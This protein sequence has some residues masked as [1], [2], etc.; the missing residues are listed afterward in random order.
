MRFRFQLL[1]SCLVVLP[2]LPLSGACRVAVAQEALAVPNTAPAVIPPQLGLELQ[3]IPAASKLVPGSPAEKAGFRINDRVLLLDGK[4]VE[5]AASFVKS[6]AALPQRQVITVTVLRAGVEMPIRA[7][8]DEFAA[9]PAVVDGKPEVRGR[10]GLALADLLLVTT[11]TPGG[12]AEQAGVRRGDRIE[13]VNYHEVST[14]SEAAKY[15]TGAFYRGRAELRLRRDGAVV[16]AALE[17]GTPLPYPVTAQDDQEAAKHFKPISELYK[18]IV[19]DPVSGSDTYTGEVEFLS[20]KVLDFALDTPK[21]GQAVY[22]L[23]TPSDYVK[24]GRKTGTVYLF[25]PDKTGIS[26]FKTGDTVYLRAKLERIRLPEGTTPLELVLTGE[27]AFASPGGAFNP[28][29]PL[30]RVTGEVPKDALSIPD[31]VK[32]TQANAAATETKLKGKSMLFE[33]VPHRLVRVG[34]D[35]S[36]S[37][38]PDGTPGS[39]NRDSVSVLFKGDAGGALKGFKKGERVRFQGRLVK[40]AVIVEEVDDFLNGGKKTERTLT[41]TFEADNIVMDQIPL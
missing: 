41:V 6:V 5:N 16:N 30:L 13:W 14:R 4:K 32:Q 24:A 29:R 27:E 40:A 39:K 31:V 28:T 1:A 37:F 8:L 35:H 34:R 36:I 20:G 15:L 21:P 25:W 23:S 2:L 3:I 22:V 9:P 17:L 10:L 26:R 38:Y 11:V 18:A 33:G 19:D 12:L 7:T